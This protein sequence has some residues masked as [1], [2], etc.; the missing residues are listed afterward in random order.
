MA[1]SD[2]LI[3]LTSKKIGEDTYGNKYYSFRGRRFVVYNGL[4]EPTKVPPMWHAWLHFLSESP[5]LDSDL[6]VHRWQQTYVPTKTG[7]KDSY[8]PKR[9]IV[10]SEY[11]R[12]N[13]NKE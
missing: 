5:P 6:Q 2:L 9:E 7:S 1:F 10:S 4:V 12:W 8:F 3:R 11:V 13:P